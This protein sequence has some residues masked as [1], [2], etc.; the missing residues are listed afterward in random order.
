MKLLYI[1]MAGVLLAL[2]VVGFVLPA[3][4]FT[5]FLLGA[6]Y[7]GAKGSPELTNR[8]KATEFYQQNMEAMVS[9]KAMTKGEKM[10]ILAMASIMILLVI[11]W[12]PFVLLK[13][14]LM[15][16]VCVKYYIFIKVIPTR[17]V[18]HD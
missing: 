18:D 13:F 16:V 6:T 7:F 3:I 2:S 4:P 1:A 8:F 14:V 11:I 12:T 17:E 5:P 9:E 15:A 10:K